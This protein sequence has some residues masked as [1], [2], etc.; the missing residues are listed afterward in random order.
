MNRDAALTATLQDMRANA[1]AFAHEWAGERRERAEKDTFWNEFFQIFGV[2]RR[3]VGAVFEYV[4]R[5]YSTGNHGFVDL[6]W[7]RHIGVEH[8]SA[9][10]DLAAAMDQLVDYLPGVSDLDLP[11]LLVVCDFENFVVRD[12]ET[13]IETRFT[14]AELPARIE[15]FA[16]LA[17]YTRSTVF[18]DEEE[19]NLR[20]TQLLAAIHDELLSFRY[21]S[22]DTRVLLVRLLYCLFA[23]DTGVWAHGSAARLGDI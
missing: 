16:F 21:P 20:A 8:K 14:L 2:G 19:A 15:M 11:Q 17:G 1:A 7:P 10:E 12:T 9:G 5:R 6:L 18:E 23:D 4:A 22:H 3:R 13:G